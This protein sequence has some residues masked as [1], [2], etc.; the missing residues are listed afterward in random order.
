MCTFLLLRRSTGLRA[1]SHRVAPIHPRRSNSRPVELP[2][3]L[4]VSLLASGDPAANQLRAQGAG[5]R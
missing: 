5:E 3:G 2:R 4:A 1:L